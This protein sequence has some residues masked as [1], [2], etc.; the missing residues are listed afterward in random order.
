MW[1]TFNEEEKYST[2]ISCN[3]EIILKAFNEVFLR[4]IALEIPS[5][6]FLTFYLKN[7]IFIL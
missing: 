5:I 3:H 2:I 6:Y 7:R 1:Q 4:A